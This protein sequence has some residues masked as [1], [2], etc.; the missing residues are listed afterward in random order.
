MKVITNVLVSPRQTR[1]FE[2]FED[3]Y[4]QVPSQIKDNRK[5]VIDL[6]LLKNEKGKLYLVEQSFYKSQNE[7]KYAI[8]RQSGVYEQIMCEVNSL[9]TSPCELYFCCHG[10][11][12]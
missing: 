6:N 1:F 7:T 12:G 5:L 3:V 4:K 11:D 10:G 8:T 2:A 9:I